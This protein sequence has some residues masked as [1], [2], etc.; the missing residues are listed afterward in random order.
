MLTSPIDLA[1]FPPANPGEVRVRDFFAARIERVRPLE[2]VVKREQGYEAS[3]LR[4]DLR[5]VD[6]GDILREWEFKLHADYRA[7][8]QIQTYVALARRDLGPARIVRGVIAAFTFSDEVRLT[9][10][11]MN[12]N[13][14]LFVLPNW[15]RGA[16]SVPLQAA[17]VCLPLIPRLIVA[18]PGDLSS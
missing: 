17:G 2:K 10:E 15:M 5:T 18:T 16:G 3:N 1:H 9:N 14:E 11:S 12:L 4:A 7:I 8:G 13:L 6:T